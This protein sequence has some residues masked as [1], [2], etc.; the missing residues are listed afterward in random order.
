MKKFFSFNENLHA[1]FLQVDLCEEIYNPKN[2]D[3]SELQRRIESV[4]S[5]L[6]SQLRIDLELCDTEDA[7]Y[8]FS[9]D[10]RNNA[11]GKTQACAI[12]DFQII[13]SNFG[14]FVAFGY[15]ND[16]IIL[17]EQFFNEV[18]ECMVR[19]G[20]VVMTFEA[21]FNAPYD[22]HLEGFLDNGASWGDRY[23]NYM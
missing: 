22:G 20:F 16:S 19:E 8:I 6:E 18:S 10:F 1:L 12:P 2:L 21:A 4:K 17:D 3:L 13:F 9:L 15:L 5:T 23:F 14:D 11:R 7:S